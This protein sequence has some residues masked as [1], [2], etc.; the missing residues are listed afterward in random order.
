MRKSLPAWKAARNNRSLA[1]VKTLT[2]ETQRH[3]DLKLFHGV[4]VPPWFKGF[5]NN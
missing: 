3:R 2:T 1:K 4:S 5:S